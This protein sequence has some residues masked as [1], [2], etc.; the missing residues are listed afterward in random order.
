[1][2]RVGPFGQ[3]IEMN[4]GEPPDKNVGSSIESLH[5]IET[6][7][8]ADNVGAVPPLNVI[9]KEVKWIKNNIRRRHCRRIV[10]K[11]PKTD[12]L[13]PLRIPNSIKSQETAGVPV[14][15]DALCQC[16]YPMSAHPHTRPHDGFPSDSWKVDTNT[17]S[18][19]TDA[20][21]EVE[22]VGYGQTERKYVRVDVKTKTNDMLKLMMDIWGLDK[23]N[24]LIS[25]TGGAKNFHMTTRLKEVFRRGLMKVAKS[26]GAWI[27]TGGTNTGVMK[28]VGEAVRDYGLTSVSSTPVVA[29]GVATWGVI[30]NKQELVSKDGNGKWPAR[31][32][33]EK[34]AKVRESC[35]DPNHT[36]FILVDNGTQHNFGVE[37]PFRAEL[38]QTVANMKTDASKDAVSVPIVLLVLQGG[39]NTLQTVKQAVHNNTP[40]VVVEGSGKAADILAYAYNNSG[41]EEIEV[42]DHDGNI[43]TQMRTLFDDA[44]SSQIQEM[45]LDA[46]GT[47]NL[48]NNC[49]VVKDCLEKRD[50]INVFKLSTS[51]GSQKDIDVPILHALLK[52]NKGQ[53]FHQLRLALAWNRIDI[54]KSEI[55]TDDKLWPSGSLDE[56]MLLAIDLNRVDFVEMF[57]DNGVSLKDFLT[58]KVLL[59]LYNSVQKN[60]LLYTLLQKMK[61]KA[62][63]KEKYIGLTEVGMLLQYLLGDFY[64]PLYLREEYFSRIDAEL[65]LDGV[66]SRPQAEANFKHGMLGVALVMGNAMAGPVDEYRQDFENPYQELFTWAVL[67]NRQGMAKLFWK[68]GK[69]PTAAALVAYGLMTAMAKKTDDCELARKYRINADEFCDLSVNVLN[70]CYE[71]DES[72]AQDL[73]V[74]EL[75]HWGSAT[76]VLI[77]VETDNKQFISQTACQ[78]LLNSV[79]MGKLSLDNGTISMLA[80]VLFP[81]LLLIFMKYKDV[82]DPNNSPTSNSQTDSQVKDGEK[83]LTRRQTQPL[84]SRAQTMLHLKPAEMTKAEAENANK[85][86]PRKYNILQKFYLFYTSPVIIFVYNVLSYLTFL[87]LFSYVLLIKMSKDVSIQEIILMVWVFSIFAEEI[88]QSLKSVMTSASKTFQTKLQSY[89]TDKWNVLDVVTIFFFVCGTILRFLPYD[90]TL[91]A[92]RVILALNLITFFFRILHIFSVHKEL[93][94]KLVMIARMFFDLLYF[95]IIL[96]VFVVAYGIAAYSILYPKSEFTFALVIGVIKMAYWN[97]YGELFLEDLEQTEPGCTFDPVLYSNDTLPRCPTEVGSYVVPWLMG[98]Y[99]LF[100]NILLLNLLIAMFSYTFELT[101]LETDS[102]WKSLRFQTISE[103][104]ERPSLP[105]PFILISHLYLLLQ[106]CCLRCCRSRDLERGFIKKI[107]NER[108]IIQWENVIADAYL[109]RKELSEGENLDNRIKLMHD[110]MEI[111]MSKVEDIQDDQQNAAFVQMSAPAITQQAVSRP[112]SQ[113]TVTA[114]IPPQLE[115]R[116]GSV[117]EQMTLTCK[118]LSWIVQSL[119]ENDMAAK[120]SPPL[121]PEL[122]TRGETEANQ[123]DIRKRKQE[124]DLALTIIEKKRELHYRSRSSPYPGCSVTRFFVPDDMVFWEI[125]FPDYNPVKYLSPEVKANPYWADKEELIDLPPNKREGKIKFNTFDYSCLVDRTSHLG[126]YKTINGLPLNPFGRTGI[127]GRGLLGRWGPNHCGDPIVTRWKRDNKG[128]IIKTG[129][130]PL[131]EFV[132]IRRTDNQMWSL[133]GGMCEP[134]QQIHE[135]LRAEFSEEALGSLINNEDHKKELNT[136]LD[137]MFKIGKEVWRGYADDPRNTDNAW[138]ETLV[139]HYHD[140]DGSILNN[141]VLRAGET[142]ESASWSTAASSL[143]LHGAHLFYLK[144]VVEKLDAAF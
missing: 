74:R 64:I 62:D 34:E 130:K 79:W 21:G 73:L 84:F 127:V 108:E 131:L 50:L 115:R 78:S 54:A 123:I 101:Q 43:L 110:R 52:A 67:Q 86:Q 59:Q 35:L 97:L 124:Q 125:P 138:L 44:L 136:K 68:Q 140:N 71:L 19:P 90:S 14:S 85:N 18:L 24:L 114:K 94:P 45:V 100:S 87:G 16:G 81:P 30:Q 111:L 99:V 29:I 80:C 95:V 58:V 120:R 40:I 134:G 23:P 63:N 49:G 76:C 89:I 72:K 31:Y 36:H 56:I 53:D 113:Q 66:S 1:M 26:T 122:Q 109:T 91:E 106:F 121:L 93:G 69:E 12:Q 13:P 8:S 3:E 4:E 128:Q 25:V 102:I 2:A 32:R 11:A 133:P 119:Q 70:E 47:K 6:A 135:C 55:F 77:A 107:P 126:D 9:S 42:T 22:F 112:T 28:H 116:I 105:A 10:E 61:K 98:L 46:Y 104:C 27:I 142:V 51:I 118:A 39:P 92:A 7:V 33:I 83:V 129:G 141:F 65:E 5:Y 20:F 57:L 17:Y 139:F 41:E 137:K 38:E 82:D 132:S 144:K 143:Q 117:E 37:I 75:E 15:N 48:V 96:M 60:S 103:Y 88:R